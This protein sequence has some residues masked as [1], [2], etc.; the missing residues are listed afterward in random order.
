M[1]QLT[2]A[3]AACDGELLGGPLGSECEDGHSER[4]ISEGADKQPYVSGGVR[5]RAFS[6]GRKTAGWLDR[7]C[8]RA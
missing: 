7:G 4:E 8:R 5:R 1:F 6:I 3:S 2:G